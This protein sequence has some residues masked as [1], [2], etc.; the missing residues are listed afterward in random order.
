MPESR[1]AFHAGAVGALIMCHATSQAGAMID[2]WADAVVSYDAGANPAGGYTDDSTALGSPERFTGE[3]TPFP[4]VVGLFSPAFGADEIV[5]IGAGGWLTVRFDEP[6]VDDASNPFGLD[7]LVFGNAG[8]IGPG[9]AGDPPAMFG[10]G[11]VAT[12]EVS[13]DGVDWRPLGARHLDLFPTLGYQDSG[14]F[15]AAPGSVLTD[16]T[17]PVDPSIT[18]ADFAGLTNAQIAALY[19]GSGGGVGFDL[20]G[21]GLAE[22]FFV[23]VSNLSADAFEI[24]ALADVSVP[25]PA[26]VLVMAPA[27]A[28]LY[29]RKR[30]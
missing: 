23:R 29:R 19:D 27:G 16:F 9:V 14:P 26:G 6:V 10:V 4:G 28:F 24:D 11:G 12:I 3:A 5:S 1:K 30:R 2:P 20:A 25:S 18:L 7:L 8:I 13:A 15:D 17:R 21:T 22:I